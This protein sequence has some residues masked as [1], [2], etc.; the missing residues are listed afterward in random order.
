MDETVVNHIYVTVALLVF[1]GL[2]SISIHAYKTY[3]S[4]M[5]AS[6]ENIAQ[7]RYDLVITPTAG[8]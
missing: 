7:Q 8:P 1:L 2:I 3:T 6:N 5:K 4:T